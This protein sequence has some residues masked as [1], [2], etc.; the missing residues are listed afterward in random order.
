MTEVRKR[1]AWDSSA[2]NRAAAAGSVTSYIG[3]CSEV[4]G[5]AAWEIRD[6]HGD[7]VGTTNAAANYSANPAADEFGAT[8][9]TRL[10]Y[11]GGAERFTA[12]SALGII[13]MGVRLHDPHPR[14]LPTGRP[15][16]R[17]TRQH[18]RVHRARSGQRLRPRRRHLLLL[19]RLLSCRRSP[20]PKG[21][22]GV[23]AQ[24]LLLLPQR[25]PDTREN[26][27]IDNAPI[28]GKTTF[29]KAAIGTVDIFGEFFGVGAV[30][31]A[32]AASAPEDVAILGGISLVGTAA[33]AGKTCADR[34]LVTKKCGGDVLTRSLCRVLVGGYCAG[35]VT[36]TVINAVS[37]GW[38]HVSE[39]LAF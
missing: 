3:G 32:C 39:R 21:Q 30:F 7:A 16:P 19:R 33:T 24:Q 28:Y 18:I 36:G 10:G 13:R 9:N 5:T 34:G 17:R 15:D 14:P 26:L 8:P 37:A 4:A 23:T 6:R 20:N 12:D 11:L 2:Y 38:D 31:A 27:A 25:Q 22:P 1:R 29:A 35:R